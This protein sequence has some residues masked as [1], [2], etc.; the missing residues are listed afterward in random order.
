M[1]K[2]Y[3]AETVDF[4]QRFPQQILSK[5]S[6][7]LAEESLIL[8]VGSGPGRDALLLT[9]LGLNVTCIDASTAMVGLCKQKGL[10]AIEADFMNLPFNNNSFDG[11]WAYTSLLH[12]PK[13]DLLKAF[14]ELL[15]VL[16]PDGIIGLGF[17]EGEFEG[18]RES[19]GVN[20]PRYFTFYTKEE[21]NK[22]FQKLSLKVLYF[23]QFKPGSK[24]YLNYILKY[25]D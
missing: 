20:K 24:N 7:S 10:E 19:S 18:F 8:D 21:L 1:A 22:Y 14:K 23:E 15:R 25:E 12:V 4:W 16:K 2:E 3:D 11:I 6:E 17:I 9:N 13:K 5:F